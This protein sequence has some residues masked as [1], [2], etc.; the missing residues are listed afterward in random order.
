[1]YQHDIQITAQTPGGPV[2]KTNSY[3]GAQHSGFNDTIS[4]GPTTVPNF[5][6][7]VSQAVS[8]VI[9]CDR[10]VV[11]TI[12]DD[13]SPDATINLLANKPLIWTN[14]AYFTNPLGAVDVTSLKAVLAAGDDATLL[15][16]VSYD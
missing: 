16:D 1:M 14:D 8:I 4:A 5:S 2:Q 15:I 12:N 7:D 9:L 11:L 13:G 10:D 3:S 6:V